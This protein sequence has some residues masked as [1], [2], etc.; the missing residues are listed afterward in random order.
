MKRLGMWIALA[1]VGGWLEGG[2]LAYAG[3]PVIIAPNGQYL[4][5]LNNNPYDPNSVADPYG[6]YGSPYAPNSINNPYGPYG[7]PYSP[8]SATNPY[9]TGGVG[10]FTPSLPSPMRLPMLPPFGR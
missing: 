7:S 5:T 8:Q 9:S 1:L 6:P 2:V 3:S 10:T 4:G